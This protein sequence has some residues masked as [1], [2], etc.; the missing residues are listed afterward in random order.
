M[1]WTNSDASSATGSSGGSSRLIANPP[2]GSP[3]FLDKGLRPLPSLRIGGEGTP[4]N[5]PIT[6]LL[7]DDVR[8][9]ASLP[10]FAGDDL[11]LDLIGGHVALSSSWT[12]PLSSQAMARAHPLSGRCSA[13][14]GGSQ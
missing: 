5:A 3:A 13:L 2:W 6:A 9:P 10:P 7:L 1:S 4:Y 11:N 12:L 8:P 14:P